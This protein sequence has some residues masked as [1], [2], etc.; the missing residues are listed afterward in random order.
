MRRLGTGLIVAAVVGVGIAAV[1]DALP[2]QRVELPGPPREVV[3]A[4]RAAGV[5]GTLTY[6]DEACRLHAIR[7]PSLRP[8]KAPGIETCE[9]H[10]PTGGIGAWKG[11]VV[12]AGF[13]YQ[14]VQVVLARNDLARSLRRLGPEARSRYGARQ[15]VG[16]G[17][18]RYAVLA[19]STVAEW[20]QVLLFFTGRRVV[21]SV[22]FRDEPLVLRPSPSG[23]Y[24]AVLSRGPLGLRVFTREGRAVRLPRL[25][26]AHA[27][28]WSPGE[29]WAAMATRA[30]IFVFST[31][32]PTGGLIR[33]P[34]TA[35]DLDWSA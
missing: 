24:V 34:R 2:E 32:R 27:I 7:L 21:G 8:A 9:P 23:R 29:R 22:S 6:S 33:I 5:R 15:A 26:E 31:A 3:D 30:S 13:G 17:D 12:W 16:L 11:D 19:A 18:D 35:R 25:T 20:E 14:T 1:V 28:A 10:V 4:L